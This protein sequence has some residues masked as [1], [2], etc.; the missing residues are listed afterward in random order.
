MT[1]AD[2]DL[3]FDP[4]NVEKSSIRVSLDTA[5][6]DTAQD[7]RDQ[8]LRSDDFL[9]TDAFPDDRFRQY[10]D[11][12]R[13]HGGRWQD[14]RRPDDPRHHAPVVL[15]TEF[16]GIVPNMQGGRRVAFS[17]SIK[18]D[19]EEFGLTWNVALERGGWLVSREIKIKIE[20]AAVSSVEQ[21]Q[22]QADAE[23]ELTER[24]AEAVSA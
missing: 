18:I 8:H 7:A 6:I 3:D 16:A 13:R 9:K 24:E 12:A 1:I 17:A 5:P 4:D 14:S 20:I 2:L 11:R 21:A 22:A 15:D 23:T 10:E 19:R